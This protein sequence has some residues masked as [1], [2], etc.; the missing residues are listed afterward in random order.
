MMNKKGKVVVRISG[1]LGNQLFIHAAALALAER[2]DRS[3]CYDLTD[4]LIF[5][6]RKY[7][8]R[9]FD[10]PSR[11]PHW[12]WLR[13]GLYLLAYIVYKRVDARLFPLLLRWMNV[14]R[15]DEKSPWIV[16]PTFFDP[17]IGA[18]SRLLYVD[19]NRQHLAY[20]PSE[21]TVRRAFRFVNAPCERNRQ[22]LARF[23]TGPSVS[24][25]IR[26]GDYL[27]TP[28]C[29]VLGID[30]YRKATEVIRER[31]PAPLWV[32]FSDDIP[33]CRTHFGFLENAVFVEGNE[34]EPWEDLR[35]MAACQH[36]VIANSSF[37]WW[38]ACLGRDP[39]GLTVAPEYWFEN[40]PTQSCL[41]K[42]GWLT[43][44]SFHDK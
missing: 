42:E 28:G 18:S 32:V 7:Q 12:T 37:S 29:S 17:S 41:L 31:E 20:L 15:F 30:Y 35:L 27:V 21:A 25:H 4:F 38:G 10:G 8:M 5:H 11:T 9:Q 14:L 2:T 24:V 33:W 3:L 1:G 22:S 43:V 6:G 16:E 13:S 34:A 44:P 19:G 23:E 36:H 26:R 40:L 39:D